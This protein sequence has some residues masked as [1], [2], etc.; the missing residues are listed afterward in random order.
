M[1]NLY[2]GTDLFY[3]PPEHKEMMQTLKHEITKWRCY[4]IIG[5]IMIPLVGDFSSVSWYNKDV[6]EHFIQHAEVLIVDT[7][8]TPFV[9]EKLKSFFQEHNILLIECRKAVSPRLYFE[10]NPPEVKDHILTMEY[11]SSIMEVIS[12]ILTKIC[13][14]NASLYLIPCTVH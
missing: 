14:H 8:H 6:Y 4:P 10:L 11:Q 2:F 9:H 5:E 1:V 12:Y 3:A 13:L 7:T